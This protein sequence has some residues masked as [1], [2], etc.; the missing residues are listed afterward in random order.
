MNS[1]LAWSS[2]STSDH[3]AYVGHSVQSI[4]NFTINNIVFGA[5]ISTILLLTTCFFYAICKIYANENPTEQVAAG[6]ERNPKEPTGIPAPPNNTLNISS[7]SYRIPL[8]SL[9]GQSYNQAQLISGNDIYNI[10]F[11]LSL[12]SR[13]EGIEFV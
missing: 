9:D 2:N 10:Y 7:F 11:I 5:T 6:K 8:Q 13:L 12:K 4:S 3:V 1:T